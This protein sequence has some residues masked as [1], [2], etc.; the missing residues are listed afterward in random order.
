MDNF[1]ENFLATTYTVNSAHHRLGLLRQGLEKVFFSEEADSSR[2]ERY[3]AALAE[4]PS[5]DRQSLT[6]LGTEYLEEINQDNLHKVLANWRQWLDE[7]PTITI[8]VPVLFTET[9][10]KELGQWCRAEV[11]QS[12]LLELVVEP[13]VVGGCAFIQNSTYYD[14]SLRSRLAE[15]EDVIP[16]IVAKYESV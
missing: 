4:L 16:T 10:E 8:Y 6:A 15:K 5:S 2:V 9:Q 11:A 12:V 3:Q 14:L 7:L 1:K 13:A